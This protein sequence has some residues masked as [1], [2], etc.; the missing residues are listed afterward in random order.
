M[1]HDPA[2]HEP[3]QDIPWDEARAHAMIERIVRDTE[4][5]FSAQSHW[6]VHPRDA[7]GGPRDPA[8]PLY[9][10]ACGV[11]WALHY[12]DSVGAARLEQ[13]IADHVDAL[14]ALNHA[15]LGDSADA[16]A[17]SYLIGDTGILLLADS[18]NPSDA[19]A[20][21][22]ESLATTLEKEFANP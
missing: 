3:L 9:H 1:L 10:G 4:A 22:L 20:D 17:A 21:R 5:H 6:P 14:L 16:E 13:P 19:H 11:F 18:L 12:L 7:D 8:Y 15:A 2:R